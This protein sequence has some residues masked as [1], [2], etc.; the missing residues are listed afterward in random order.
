V[1]L[2]GKKKRLK[3]G[4]EICEKGRRVSK[5]EEGKNSRRNPKRRGR[6]V[7]L[8]RKRP[9]PG[10]S[11]SR[12]GK[13]LQNWAT[14]KSPEQNVLGV[15]PL[16]T[17]NTPARGQFAAVQVKIEEKSK[18]IDKERRALEYH[19]RKKHT[20]TC[21]GTLRGKHSTGKTKLGGG[22]ETAQAKIRGTRVACAI[23]DI[24]R[25]RKGTHNQI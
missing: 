5:P 14:C 18:P 20:Q 21:S 8:H 4:A 23:P 19:Y 17:I 15:R 11:D 13:N 25:S 3:K 7:D 22:R 24:I 6:R 1:P 9:F 12:L 10:G 2:R 16:Q